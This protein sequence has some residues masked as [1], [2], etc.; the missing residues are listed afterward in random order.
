MVT[1][2]TLPCAFWVGGVIIFWLAPRV[3]GAIERD[4]CIGRVLFWPTAVVDWLVVAVASP[5]WIVKQPELS[6]DNIV[7]LN[8][9]FSVNGTYII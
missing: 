3:P 6:H 2:S 9:S 1:K 7:C 8:G 5:A 4:S